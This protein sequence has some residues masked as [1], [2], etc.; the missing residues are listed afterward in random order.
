MGASTQLAALI[1]RELP[2]LVAVRRDLH[3]N[4]EIGLCETRTSQTIQD[5]LTSLGIQFEAGLGGG[6]GVLA[7]LPGAGDNTVG[8]RADIDALPI[9]EATGLSY[10]STRPGVMHA[11]GH[12]GHTTILLGVARVLAELAKTE[13]LPRP[14]TLLFQPAEENLGGAT[15]MIRDG[16]LTGRIGSPI[17]EIYGLHGWP[18]LP[19]G[20]VGVRNGAALAATDYFSISVHGRGAHAACPHLSN[21]PI[22]A[23]AGVINALQTVVSRNTDPI[24]AVVL[25]ICVV[26]AGHAFNVIP[27]ECKIEG[28]IRTLDCT[29]RAHTIK[30]IEEIAQHGAS[31]HGCTVTTEIVS[32]CPATINHPTA[33][34]FV[35]H[36]ATQMVGTQLVELAAP[37]M[38]GEDFAYYG[39][40]IP[41]SFFMLGLQDPNRPTMPGLHHPGFDFNDD[42]IAI[43]IEAMCRI[44]LKT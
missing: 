30:R 9:T 38:G 25:S 29:V 23:V 36:A 10:A 4:P 17:K 28:T 12:D 37:F 15:H 21:D 8:L 14:V 41:A 24:D 22:V 33:T 3:A 31:M 35:R 19:V 42:A 1:K 5:E 44:A 39:Q 20:T 2:S 18:W 13:R 26:H 43:G 11:C 32:G 34:D 6:T 7:H 16:C 40:H 27:Q